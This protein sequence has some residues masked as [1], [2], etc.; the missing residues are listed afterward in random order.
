M[1]LINTPGS[2]EEASSNESTAPRSLSP[3]S[4]SD[5]EVEESNSPREGNTSESANEPPIPSRSRSSA[6][7]NNKLEET[8]KTAAFDLSTGERKKWLGM[9]RRVHRSMCILMT[10]FV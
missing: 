5:R 7:S 4:G 10:L 6:Q 2:A 3:S 8:P 9:N 1:I